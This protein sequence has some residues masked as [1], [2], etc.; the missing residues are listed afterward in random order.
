MKNKSLNSIEKAISYPV[1][2]KLSKGG[3]PEEEKPKPQSNVIPF[4]IK[5]GMPLYEWWK[6]NKDKTMYVASVEELG[7]FLTKFYSEKQIL[8]MINLQMNRLE[9]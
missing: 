1:R 6:T 7:P 4:P 2:N 8:D 5:P 9:V 3:K